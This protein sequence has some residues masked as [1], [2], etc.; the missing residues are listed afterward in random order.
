[1]NKYPIGW[2]VKRLDEISKVINGGTPKTKVEEFWGGPHSWITPAEMGKKKDP[3]VSDTDR[4]LTDAGLKHSSAQLAPPFSVI[5]S[6]RAPIGHLVINTAPMATNQGCRILVPC[7]E[8]NHKYLFYFL[9]HSVNILNELGTGTTFKE[10][11]A[12]KLKGVQIPLPSLPEQKRI[13]AILDDVFAGITQAVANTE[14]NLANARELFESYLYRVFSSIDEE[15]V[16]TTIGDICSKVEYG[17]AKKSQPE[18]MVPVIRMGNIQNRRITW[19]DLV[20]TNDTKEIEKYLLKENDVLFN[21]T[22]SAELV[23]KTAIYKG[24]RPAIFAGYLIRIHS[25]ADFINPEFLNY[26]LNSYPARKYGETVMSRSINQANI[27]GTILKH[28]P[29][30]VPPLNTQREI[31][32]KLNDLDEETQ[33]LETIYQKKLITLAELKQ[34]IL[35]KAFAGELTTDFVTQQLEN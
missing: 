2:Q 33:H 7:E 22:N 14:K 8:L 4:T 23:G 34:S 35:Q 28:Y 1:M 20:F 21:R 17:S 5:L 29:I 11:S 18:G 31:V 16:R 10:L 27:N 25:K 24:E 6:T 13:V 15:W 26:Y 9:W 32:S 3:Y 12:G 30:P 19:D